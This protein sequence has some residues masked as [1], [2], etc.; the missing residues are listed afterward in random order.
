MGPFWT[1]LFRGSCLEDFV[2]NPRSDSDHPRKSIEVV[3]GDNKAIWAGHWLGVKRLKESER[4]SNWWQIAITLKFMRIHSV[5]ST[6]AART[7]RFQQ[8]AYH[9]M[10]D[11]FVLSQFIAFKDRF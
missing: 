10:A 5:D 8:F 3:S 7:I 2:R 6:L 9:F 1:I 11:F 4:E